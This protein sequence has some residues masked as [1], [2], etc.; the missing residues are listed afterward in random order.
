MSLKHYLNQDVILLHE[1]PLEYWE[2]NRC[3][4]PNL[5]SITIKYLSIVAT[6]VPCEKIF[7]EV[8]N[9]LN[10]NRNR[11]KGERV[12]KLLFLKSLEFS[13]WHLAD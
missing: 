10:E 1:D 9:I 7:S 6:S 13:E 11:T 4:F 3:F 2:R 12:S 8:G 5:A